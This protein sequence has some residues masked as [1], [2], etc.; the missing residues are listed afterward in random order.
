MSVQN[1]ARRALGEGAASHLVR[2]VSRFVA[3]E[4]GRELYEPLQKNEQFKECLMA[5]CYERVP[6]VVHASGYKGVIIAPALEILRAFRSELSHTQ[7]DHP[8]LDF[9]GSSHNAAT[10]RYACLERYVQF[11]GEGSTSNVTTF[12]DPLAQFLRPVFDRVLLC[13]VYSIVACLDAILLQ[14]DNGFRERIQVVVQE[15]FDVTTETWA[16]QM[17]V[18]RSRPQPL[19][20]TDTGDPRQST[21]RFEDVVEEVTRTTGSG[22]RRTGESTTKTVKQKVRSQ[23]RDSRAGTDSDSDEGADRVTKAVSFA[24]HGANAESSDRYSRGEGRSKSRHTGR[25]SRDD[26]DD[27]GDGHR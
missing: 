11:T 27:E 22:E 25:D 19:A 7:S 10:F 15:H 1:T 20:L 16:I 24:S 21:S 9:F 14:Q 3:D 26:A 23:M 4:I 8:A 5:T 17:L 12:P 2:V 13:C 6:S 18:N